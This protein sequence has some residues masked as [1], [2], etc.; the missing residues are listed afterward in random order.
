MSLYSVD[1]LM[2]EARRLAVEYRKTTG[3]PLPGV[4]GE[5]A[6]YDAARLLDLELCKDAGGYD[7]VGKGSREGKRVQIK[8]RAIFDDKKSGQRVGQL[9]M[10]QNWDSVVLVLMDEAFEPQEIYEADRDEILDAMDEGGASKRSKRGAMS[11]ARFKAIGN[12]VWT[13]DEGEIDDEVWD[14]R[15]G[16]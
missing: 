11:V 8:G 7:A 3:K 15:S 14:N 6:N 1:K 10:E 9:K 12:L 2:S 5:L 4:S 13:R 16:V